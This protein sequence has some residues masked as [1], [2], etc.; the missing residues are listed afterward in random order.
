M[1]E[2][3]PILAF[4]SSPLQLASFR[5]SNHGERNVRYVGHRGMGGDTTI[6]GSALNNPQVLAKL[7]SLIGPDRVEVFLPNSLNALFYL[8]ASHPRVARISYLDEGRLTQRFLAYQHRNPS[9]P[10]SSLLVAVFGIVRKLPLRL[11]PLLYRLLCALLRLMIVQRYEHDTENFP[12]LTIERRWKAGCILCHTAIPSTVEAVETVNLLRDLDFPRDAT[13]DACVFLHPKD[14]ATSEQIIALIDKLT[15]ENANFGRLLI[16]PHPIF[17]AFPGLLESLTAQLDDNAIDWD[18][19]TLSGRQEVTIE[20]YARGVRVFIVND[21][22]VLDT[23]DA[24]PD[25]FK[26][27]SMIR[28]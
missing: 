21:S 10:A 8:C 12:Y 2:K 19:V 5:L 7:D 27:L 24:L 15:V 23:I 13:G 3:L 22:T 28:V 6:P 11:Q 17:V 25:L 14:I 9:H 4:V 16:R 26:D 20:M 18:V 1:T